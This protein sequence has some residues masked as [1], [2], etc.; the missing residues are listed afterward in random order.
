MWTMA[1]HWVSPGV[2]GTTLPEGEPCTTLA[3]AAAM[4]VLKPFIFRVVLIRAGEK[5]SISTEVGVRLGQIS[6]FSLLI[7][8]LGLTL[9]VAAAVAAAG[10]GGLAQRLEPTAIQINWEIFGWPE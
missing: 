6:E 7:A 3:L 8:A 9:G 10:S 2:S 1:S 5:P 4:L